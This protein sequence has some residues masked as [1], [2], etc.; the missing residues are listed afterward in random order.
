MAKLVGCY[1]AGHAP[2]IA[3]SWDSMNK[4]TR[5]WL[6]EK[7]GELSKRVKK[8]DPD[9]IIV[10]STDHWSNFFLDNIPAFCIGIGD[11]HEGPPEPFMKPVFPHDLLE[12]HGGLGRHILE[13]ALSSEF[14]PSYSMRLKLD[15]GICVPIWQCGFETLPAIIPVYLN[16]VEQPF[17]TPLR[18]IKWGRMLRDAIES[19]PEDLRVAVMGTGGMSHSIG[20]TTFGWVDEPFD[21]A[22]IKLMQSASDEELGT[23]L[24][25]M[26]KVTGNGGAEMRNWLCAHGA[27]KGQGFD[28]IGYAPM[29]DMLI[30]CGVAEWR[31]AA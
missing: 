22:C 3:R 17:A 14:D 27:A 20:E 1:A 4:D 25:K 8:A 12:G 18:C 19:Y 5:T 11:E 23:E 21:E 29:H 15:H 6:E 30:G 24:E 13:H 26:L 31:L 7:F 10:H 28:L 2:N 16:L 9:V